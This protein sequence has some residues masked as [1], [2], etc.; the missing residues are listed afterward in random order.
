MSVMRPK[1]CAV[2]LVKVVGLIS[3]DAV[4]RETNESCLATL[5][6][7]TVTTPLLAWFTLN[8]TIPPTTAA[9]ARP[10]ATFCHV[11]I[12]FL[13]RSLLETT[14]TQGFCDAVLRLKLIRPAR[15]KCFAG[16]S[17]LIHA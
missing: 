15:V 2:M 4:T 1:P 14:C 6:V 3:P 7:C 5:A 13:S 11:F 10:L 8:Q 16:E 17:K 9:A 12:P